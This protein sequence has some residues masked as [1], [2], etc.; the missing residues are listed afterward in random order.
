MH[1]KSLYSYIR[2]LWVK[3][4]AVLLPGEAKQAKARLKFLKM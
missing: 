1:L 2:I 4:A 3:M